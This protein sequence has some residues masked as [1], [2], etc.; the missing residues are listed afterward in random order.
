MCGLRQLT[1]NSLLWPI[2]R[3]SDEVPLPQ[4]VCIEKKLSEKHLEKKLW[5]KD[6]VIKWP[7]LIHNRAALFCHCI[8]N[9]KGVID[10]YTVSNI[11]MCLYSVFISDANSQNV[12]QKEVMCS[13]L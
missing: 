8:E 3:C 4:R 9:L 12:N 13:S 6:T 2:L 1:E 11:I 10:F 7:Y 5:I